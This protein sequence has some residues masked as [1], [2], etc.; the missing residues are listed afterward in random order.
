M[1]SSE[2]GTG[3]V[4]WSLL[5]LFLFVIWVWLV[6]VVFGD[7]RHSRDLSG[8]G[9]GLWCGVI[10][11]LPYLGVFIY[12]IARGTGMR[13]HA[14]LQSREQDKLMQRYLDDAARPPGG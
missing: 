14:G 2:F 4:F 10:I 9:K 6:I 5:W 8:W 11:A 7:I 12:L 1:L 3:Q 13:R